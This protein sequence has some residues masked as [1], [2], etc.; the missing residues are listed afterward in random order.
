MTRGSRGGLERPR[1]IPRGHG[2]EVPG[3]RNALKVPGTTTQ[4]L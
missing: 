2:E 4:N 3:T 1:A